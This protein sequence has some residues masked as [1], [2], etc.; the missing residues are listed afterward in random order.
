VDLLDRIRANR[1]FCT[2]PIA[3]LKATM[4]AT[5]SLRGLKERFHTI[6]SV[7]LEVVTDV[8]VHT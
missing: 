3:E 6:R 1:G 2:A 7:S 8:G 5:R 4:K